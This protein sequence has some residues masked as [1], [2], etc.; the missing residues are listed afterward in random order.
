MLRRLK[1][2]VK[3]LRTRT[4]IQPII[5]PTASYELLKGKVGMVTGGS[6]GI[7]FAIAQA[8]VAAGA[9]VYIVGRRE[10]VLQRA[11]DAI[12]AYPLPLDIS[13]VAMAEAAIERLSAEED[14]SLL[15]NAAGT[16]GRDA[17]LEVTEQTYD[18]VMSV[19]VKALYFI[20][21][22]VARQMIRKHI[23]GHILNVSSASSL[24]PS[25]TPYEI[26]KRAVDGITRGMAHR[27]IAHGIVVN[28]IVPGPTATPMM[29]RS[30]DL[31]WPANPS[32]R[33]STPEE[34]AALA[35]FMLGPQGD[36]IVGDTFF[37][38]GGSGTVCI[39]K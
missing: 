34:V 10:Q 3:A 33:M 13:D 7:G 5:I 31:N 38:T 25:W 20:S 14:I 29:H 12:G 9:K 32:G 27:L 26:S 16:H 37:I 19:N 36:G 4:K 18:E 11:A 21:Q 6:S 30:D 39:D 23:A 1:T 22:A 24:K 8:M 17:F 35:L 15:V 2:A 28:G